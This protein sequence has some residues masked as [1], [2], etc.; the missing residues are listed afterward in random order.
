MKN[1]QSNQPVDNS[2]NM[3]PAVLGFPTQIS[4]GQRNQGLTD[5]ADFTPDHAK[6]SL[7]LATFLQDQLLPQSRSNGQQTQKTPSN[8]QDNPNNEQSEPNSESIDIEAKFK[9][10][11]K[12]I[13]NELSQ[14]KELVKEAL[15][16]DKKENGQEETE[17]DT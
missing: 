6:A 1:T 3:Q 17:Q 4:K 8:S 13:R 14:I 11:E 7:G 10:F 2:Q 16:E 9:D 12:D 15:N 5:F